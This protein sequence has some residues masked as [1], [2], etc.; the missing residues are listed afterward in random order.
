MSFTDSSTGSPT[1]WSWTLRGYAHYSTA[2]NPSHTYTGAGTYT[3][4]L[5]AYNQYGNNTNTKTNYITVTGGS[6]VNCYVTSDA[7]MSTG[8]GSVLSG[9]LSDM[10]YDDSNY[11]IY[12]SDT[13][14]PLP[15]KGRCD[16]Y[17]YFDTGYTPSQVSKI[18]VDYKLSTNISGG[19]PSPQGINLCICTT[20]GT[21]YTGWTG[22]GSGQYS[23]P[24]YGTT[25]TWLSWE[26]TSVSQYM[27]NSGEIRTQFCGGYNTGMNYTINMNVARVVLTL[28]GNQ[29][30]ASFTGTPTIGAPPL[31]VSFT[32][33]S[34]GSPTAWSWTFGD[35]G[36]STV[37]SPAIA[38]RGP[39]S[40]PSC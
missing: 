15:N 25:D 26:T 5:T 9:A 16:F 40:S 17:H 31:A 14:D 19:G 29:P 4:A 8:W 2:Q 22:M 39:V 30:V 12:Q 11:R 6:T 33:T 34:T 3:V 32:D 7:V 20:N 1:A 24:A 21:S 13:T 36:T 18:H 38:T 10:D 23:C 35:G 28:V 27:T 37:Q